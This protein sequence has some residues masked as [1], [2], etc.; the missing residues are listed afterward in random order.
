M[1]KAEIDNII[2]NQIQFWKKKSFRG[3]DIGDI[4]TS[5][6]YSHL[7]VLKNKFPILKYAYYPLDIL[8]K[9]FPKTLRKLFQLDT[10]YS[11]AQANAVIIGGLSQLK[12]P[13][14]LNIA[15]GLVEDIL[16]QANKDYKNLCWGQPY[17]WP[18]RDF[19]QPNV[20]RATVSSQVLQAFLDLYEAT[21][22]SKF[23]LYA[24]QTATF[25]AEEFNFTTDADGDICFSYT[26]EDHYCIHNASMLI[27]AAIIRFGAISG[28]EKFITL[29]LKAFRFTVKQQN[30]DG[31]W[32]YNGKP[33]KP[34]KLIDNYHTGYVLESL[35]IGKKYLK[36]RFKYN[37]QLTLG[38]SFYKNH[39][40]TKDGYAKYRP[41]KVYPIDI[42]GCAQSIITLCLEHE[43]HNKDSSHICA[44]LVK[45]TI[46]SFYAPN[47]TFGYRK[48]S[49]RYDASS[50]IRWGDSWMI[51]ALALYNT[52]INE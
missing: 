7:Y 4:K 33:E 17:K 15:N 29:G 2:S 28:K 24:E 45:Q 18:S 3:P 12:N 1:H 11:F 52:T 38:L 8:E 43:I 9:R 10:N 34:N 39:L 16:S 50:Y 36:Q 30:P 6:I 32:D 41:N 19:M 48:Y 25:F 26:T 47:G 40:I 31:S 5:K 42:Q 13:E 51:R 20:P 23:L 35:L 46:T 37:E 14:Y 22:E 44:Q 49:N 27:A 21:G